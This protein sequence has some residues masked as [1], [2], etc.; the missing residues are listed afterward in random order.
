[1]KETIIML[2]KILKAKIS[3]LMNKNK[4]V[5][6]FTSFILWLLLAL[7][8]NLISETFVCYLEIIDEILKAVIE[9]KLLDYMI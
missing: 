1:M 5:L 9:Y 8:N 2:I 4:K 6:Y 3:I 7:Y